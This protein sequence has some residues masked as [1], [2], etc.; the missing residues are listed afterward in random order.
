MITRSRIIITAALLCHLFLA[1]GLVTS[2]TPPLAA[3]ALPSAPASQMEEVTIKAVEQEKQGSVYHLRGRVEIDYRSYILQA[4]EIT[5]N[6]DPPKQ[7][8]Q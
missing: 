4:E 6:A 3:T 5:Y 8:D 2:Q 7:S 1:P